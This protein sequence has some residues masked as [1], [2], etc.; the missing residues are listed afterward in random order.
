MTTYHSNKVYFRQ[1]AVV[2]PVHRL[3]GTEQLRY[4]FQTRPDLPDRK[5]RSGGKYGNLAPPRSDSL[6]KSPCLAFFQTNLLTT[7]LTQRFPESNVAPVGPAVA[8]PEGID[9]DP[10]PDIVVLATVEVAGALVVDPDP[11]PCRHFTENINQNN[12][13]LFNPVKVLPDCNSH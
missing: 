4:S 12:L 7:A 9:V 5:L 11:V 13:K 3:V 1:Q 6:C 8:V 2:P 10:P